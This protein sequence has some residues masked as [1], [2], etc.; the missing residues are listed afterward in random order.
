[1]MRNGAPLAN[2][3]IAP[4]EARA[5]ADLR[6]VR[7]HRL[8][9]LAAAVGVED[10]EHDI[11]LV[12]QAGLVADLGDEG[13]ADAAPADRDLEPLLGLAG[14]PGRQHCDGGE[15]RRPEPCTPHVAL[16][17]GVVFVVAARIANTRAGTGATHGPACDR[18]SN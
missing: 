1:M 5:G 2:T 12:E 13:L 16:P 4:E 17:E 15:R 3:P 6:A 11:V 7:D 9:G 18:A 8:L 10:V 14:L